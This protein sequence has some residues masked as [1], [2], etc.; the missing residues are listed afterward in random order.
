MGEKRAPS[1]VKLI[2]FAVFAS[3]AVVLVVRS[4]TLL[5]IGPAEFWVIGLLGVLCAAA[6][7]LTWVRVGTVPHRT[8]V[9]SLPVL[10]LPALAPAIPP[11]GG[12]MGLVVLGVALALLVE[13]RRV[14]VAL[15]SAGLVGAGC[16]AA[17]LV[18]AGMLSAGLPELLAVAIGSG[19]YV[20]FIVIVESLR[21][22]FTRP[23]VDLGGLRALAPGRFIVAV[24][25]CGALASGLAF[26]SDNHVPIIDSAT[27]A[28][29]VVLLGL[30]VTAVGVKAANS[31]TAMRRLLRGLIAGG[32]RLIEGNRAAAAASRLPGSGGT[33][34]ADADDIAEILCRAVEDTI[35]VESVSVR[36][37][38]P[39][40]GELGVRV[41]LVAGLSQF[42]VAVRDPMDGAFSA[43][44][45]SA[46]ETLAYTAEAVDETR[47]NIGGLTVRANT[48]PLTGLPNYGSFQVALANIND[49]RDYSEAIAVL[50]IDLDDFKRMNDRYGH[51][52]G[53]SILREIG[54]R[55][56]DVVRPHDVVARVGGDEFV[57]ILTHLKSLGEANI[58]AERIMSAT[59]EPMT[60]DTVTVLP[61]VSI[62]LAYS[63]HRET[64]IT[65]LLKDA[66][67]SMLA[68]KKSRRRGGP[69]KESSI[70]ISG[71]R[72]SEMNDIVARAIDEDLLQI[73]YQP[74]VSLVTG[75]IWAFEALVRYTHPELGPLSPSSLVEKAKGLGRLDKLTQQVAVKAMA[76]AND[77]RL[78][79]PRIVCMT[80]NVEAG[81]I[82]P[83][84][85]GD[86]VEE[87]AERYP[88]ISLCLEL[89]ER[90]MARVTPAIRA[91]AD[92]LREL[93]LMIALDD[94]GS[95]D[96]SVD[97]LV[98]MPMDIL[99][100]DRS[101]VDDL[102]DVRQREVLT[103]LQGFGDNLE[104]SMIVEGVENQAM[105]DHLGA[106]G[107]RS[108]QGFH[109]GTPQSF[110]NTVA[111]LEEFGARAV[112][113]RRLPPLVD[114]AA[115][116][117]APDSATDA[118]APAG[119]SDVLAVP[120]PV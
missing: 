58:I 95:Q 28:I 92:R 59:G 6:L 19:A 73:A 119:D 99:K 77:F 5:V 41:S 98:R 10:A 91:Q 14:S 46:I 103:A 24:V 67:R 72:S 61:V 20:V 108:A 114:A 65:E 75:Q 88:R 51:A 97:A 115:H 116:A 120:A 34:D 33:S 62:G 22:R 109:Y 110:E 76:A 84:R 107:I 50:F 15:Y 87:L 38:P 39:Q 11:A 44:D 90:S 104:Y 78:I 30:A 37:Q 89:N 112:L 7:E 27:E 3:L 47:H 70:N 26:W 105:A 55:L 45:R 18:S 31:R 1:G 42:V 66:D 29:I 2:A 4:I 68:I 13:S 32:T 93:G 71:H 85:V 69:S 52:V 25:G 57:V 35:G 23:Q 96:S 40:P 81:Q 17:V 106:L 21:R 100:I 36:T 83:K 80:I 48:D 64:D 54:H 12:G 102:D 53:D 49:N 79:E 101:L 60:V 8:P 63:A 43:D 117:A 118:A 111:R 86:F 56:S 74:I 94:Y 16:I 82:V 9:V 113:P